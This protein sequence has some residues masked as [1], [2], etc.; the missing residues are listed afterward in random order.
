M[1]EQRRSNDGYI[2]ATGMFKA[3]FP[4]ASLE[5]EEIEKKF[6]KSLPETGPEEV[7]GNVWIPPESGMHPSIQPAVAE[8]L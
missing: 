2:S 1:V 7:A 3:A 5:Q 6:V 4:W 8:A